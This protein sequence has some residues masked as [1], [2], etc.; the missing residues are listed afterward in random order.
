VS[1]GPRRWTV[2]L[3]ATAQAD[4]QDILRWTAAQFGPVQAQVY[5]KTLA[6]A[7]DALA[8][9]PTVSGAKA[10]DDIAKGLFTLHVAR[11]GRKGR[12]FVM[13]RIGLDQGSELIDVLRLLH[14]AMDLQRHLPPIDEG[15]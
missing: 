4:Y 6:A 2:R 11:R 1:A 13:F 8:A 12:H 10:R 14:D 7:L 9:G 15:K 5:T 3:A